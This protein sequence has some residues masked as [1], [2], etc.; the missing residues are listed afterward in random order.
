MALPSFARESLVRI[1]PTRTS[2]RR[3]EF[4]DYENPESTKVIK[5][6]VIDPITGA[7][8]ISNRNAEFSQWQVM[9]PA[10]ADID[11][12]D[13]IEYRGKIYQIQGSI[14]D[15]P[16]AT[17]TLDHIYFVMNRWEG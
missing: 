15:Q 11:S 8:N 10:R 3:D 16:S 17:G 7:E 6:C 13:H 4:L 2:D 1:R 12:D 9:M 5:G 14:Q